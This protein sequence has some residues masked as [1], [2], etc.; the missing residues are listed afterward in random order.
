MGRR[1]IGG[2]LDAQHRSSSGSELPEQVPVITGDLDDVAA[3]I[4]PEALDRKLSQASSVLDPGVWIAGEIRVAAEAILRK[5]HGFTL[6]QKLVADPSVEWVTSII[7]AA[8]SM[9]I[10]MVC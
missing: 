4:K 9:V 8:V 7:L 1:H 6:Y 3:A 5:H 2:R 10:I